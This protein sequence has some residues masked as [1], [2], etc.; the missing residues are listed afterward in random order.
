MKAAKNMKKAEV[1]TL[2]C[3]LFGVAGIVLYLSFSSRL[4]RA[5]NESRKARDLVAT[6]QQNETNRAAAQTAPTWQPP[7]TA[8]PVIE[9]V[10]RAAAQTAPTWPPPASARPVIKAVEVPRIAVPPPVRLEH[11]S[12]DFR[13]I[14]GTLILNRFAKQNVHKGSG[15]LTITNGLMEDT[16]VKVVEGS[17]LMAAMYVRG[18]SSYALDEVPDGVYTILYRKGFGWMADKR[19]FERGRG[20]S[21]FENDL[22][23]AT[24]VQQEGNTIRTFYDSITLTLHKV[25]DGNAPAEDISEEEFNKYQ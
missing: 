9:T 1:I 7:A 19:D 22:V 6:M 16:F 5:E 12:T 4:A 25:V 2:L 24:R 13:P 20:A 18:N 10:D 11:L 23:Y 14:S 21:R 17:R 3:G 8:R 15:K